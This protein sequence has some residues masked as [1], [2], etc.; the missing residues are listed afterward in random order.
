MATARLCLRPL[1]LL[2]VA[3]AASAC[4]DPSQ[5]LPGFQAGGP[6]GILDG[7]LT[8]T[9]PLPCTENQHVAGAAALFAFDTHMLPP[10]DGLGTTAAS[11]AAVGGDVLFGGVTDRLT[12]NGDGSPW[13]PAASTP[14]VTVSA[15]WTLGQLSG[16]EYEVRGFY[17]L[18]GTFDPVFSI[19]KLPVQGDVAGGAI[20]NAAAV[21]MGAAPVYR[22][23]ALGVRQPDGSYLIPSDGQGSNIGGIA[24]TLGLPLPLGLPIF[25]SS[26]V[27]YSPNAC[28]N[29]A[30]QSR[31]PPVGDPTKPMM[32]ADYIV[33]VFSMGDLATTESSLVLLTLSAGV[34]PSEV[35]AADGKPFFLSGKPGFPSAQSPTLAYSWQPGMFSAAS[36]LVPSL[37]PLSI[38][39]KLASSNPPKPTDDLAAQAS[40]AV[41]LQGLTLYK[42]LLSTVLWP[43]NPP[44]GNVQP[45]PTILVGLTP[46]VVCL[47]A[48]PTLSAMLVLPS[49]NDCAGNPVL[50]PNTTSLALGK[51]FGRKVVPVQG[52]LP[53]G[54]Y[55]MNL[56]YSTGQAWTVPNE[57][58]VC[59]PGETESADQMSC[60]VPGLASASRPLLA[61]QDVV[62]T[63]SAPDHPEF[64]QMHPTPTACC[65]VGFTGACK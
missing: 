27:G 29:N 45:S 36:S 14:P 6:A 18:A 26:A 13:C 38:F 9:G 30:V 11:F 42:D 28:V 23:I 57:A 21:L 31:T 53:Q 24:V 40:P 44:P 7:T 20:D 48:D 22:R 12:F 35:S 62:L 37:F 49:F 52:C 19:T 55:A 15:N 4:N 50:D 39:S 17:D 34:P 51:Q 16:G 33:P 10:P 41:I 25:H 32:P 2:A 65:P 3:A 5:F 63:I 58:G 61:S 64:C 47:P 43:G 8:Y 56:V 60:S 59:Q 54:R 1:L 46:A